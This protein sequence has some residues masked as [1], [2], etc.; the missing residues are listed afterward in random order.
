[1]D[2]FGSRHCTLSLFLLLG[3]ACVVVAT[4]PDPATLLLALFL[5]RQSG[6]GLMSHVAITSMARDLGKL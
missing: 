2:C 3:F 6:Q 1:M 5:L 4:I